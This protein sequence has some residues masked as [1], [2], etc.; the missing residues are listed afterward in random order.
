MTA[1][2]DAPALPSNRSFGLLF[3]GVFALTGTYLWWRGHEGAAYVY[4]AAALCAVVTAV[5]PD[6]L[7]PFNRAWMAFGAL[8]HRI[9]SP[10][11][12]GIMYFAVFTPFAFV[13]R[14]TGRDVLRRRFDAAA[15][16]YWI[17]REPPG[18]R[19]E[20]LGDQF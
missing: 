15:A 16:S 6:L 1:H 19:P 11:V 12:L 13:M 8:L 4:G 9:V 7:A 18:P 5:R 3:T 17:P 14:L 20:S 10:I 2:E